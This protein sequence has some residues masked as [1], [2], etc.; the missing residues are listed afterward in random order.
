MRNV[1]VLAALLVVG[2]GSSEEAPA[3]ADAEVNADVGAETTTDAPAAETEPT[4]DAAADIAPDVTGDAL[5]DAPDL[6]KTDPLAGIG[7]VT[8]VKGG[9]GFTEGTLWWPS[10][11]TLLF[12][13]IPNAK[14]HELAPPS[15]VSVFRDAS[16]KS[17]GL[18]WDPMGRLIACEHWNRRVSRTNADGSIVSIADAWEG[19]KLNSPNDVIARSDGTLYFTD[20]SYGLEGRPKELA[21]NAVFRVDPSGKLHLVET[22]MNQPNGVALSPDEKT[23][24]VSDSAAGLVNAW[25]VSADGSVTG[26]KKL[27][28]TGGGGDGMAIDDAGNLYVTTS[29]GVKVYKP[30]G[31]TWGTIPIPEGPTNCSFGGPDRKTL[32]VSAQK[33]IYSVV[34]GI[35][36]KP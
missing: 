22:G 9:Y 30:D 20:P 8:K 36:G 5:V 4:I 26:K 27:V 15:T 17:N 18:G 23:L 12:S 11:G 21:F 35:P 7:A 33:S 32:Y 29:A 34:S 28:D 14:I 19:K 31:G 3:A 16:G 1:V 2:C 24:Y 13:D 10:K 6:S 25:S